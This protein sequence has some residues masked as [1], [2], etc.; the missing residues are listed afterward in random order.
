[1]RDRHAAKLRSFTR[2]QNAL[3]RE[4]FGE[5]AKRRCIIVAIHER[6]MAAGIREREGTKNEYLKTL[7]P[8]MTKEDSS[9]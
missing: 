5:S 2:A 6:G 8:E 9:Y 1:M 7:T 3:H 4:F